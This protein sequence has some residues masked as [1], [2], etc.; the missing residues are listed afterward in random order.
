[1]SCLHT[2]HTSLIKTK[3]SLSACLRSIDNRTVLTIL[4]VILSLICFIAIA[5]HDIKSPGLYYDEVDFVNAALGGTANSNFITQRIFGVPVMIMPY[6]GAL[7]S[8]IYYPVF[9]FFGVSVLTIRLPAII[10]GAL[11][12]FIWYK[13][14]KLIFREKLYSLL[15]IVLMALDPAYIFQSKLDWGPIVLQTLF[16]GLSAYCFFRAIKGTGREAVKQW[17]PLLYVCLLL[18][19]YNK[20]NFLWFI[21]GLGVSLLIFYSPKIKEWYKQGIA[22]VIPF[23]LFVLFLGLAGIFL[24]LPS[25]QLGSSGI[26]LSTRVPYIFNLYLN[27]MNGRAVYALIMKGVLNHYSWIN[28]FNLYA[29]IIW[30]VTIIIDKVKKLR[31][32]NGL[33]RLT[34]FFMTLFLIELIQIIATNQAGGPHHIIILWPLQLIVLLLMMQ[35]IVSVLVKLWSNK[36]VYLLAAVLLLSV[37][38][39][40]EINADLAYNK[41]FATPQ[42]I[43]YRWSPAI[44][45]LSS[46]VNNNYLKVNDVIFSDWGMGNQVLTLAKSDNEK[47]RLIDEWPVFANPPNLSSQEQFYETYFHDKSDFV[48]TYSGSNEVIAGT[49]QNLFN[50]LREHNLYYT[51]VKQIP[52]KSKSD[53][54]TVYSVYLIK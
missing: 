46:Y 45:Q 6:I 15:L 37:L 39:V 25:L 23:L 4:I 5:S 44:Y 52:A 10:L 38:G 17:L 26:S 31:Q 53:I 9:L 48:V 43:S 27:T 47:K 19:L 50:F 22:F 34:Y 13:V 21:V 30:L 33:L 32:S 29:F 14:S 35:F 2:E 28:Y 20:L 1:M 7:K 11:A 24:I 49:K 36:T 12:L 40:T 3:Q 42:N 8:A 18:G 54:N 51:L 41:A 16:T